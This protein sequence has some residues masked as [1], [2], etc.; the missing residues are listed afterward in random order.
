MAV[1]YFDCESCGSHGKISFKVDDLQSTDVVYCPF[2]G[3]DIYEEEDF[4]EEEDA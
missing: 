3:G 2:C 4:E 1:K